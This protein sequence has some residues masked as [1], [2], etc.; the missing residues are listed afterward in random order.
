MELKVFELRKQK[1]HFREVKIG[2]QRVCGVGGGVKEVAE[3]ILR[4][5]SVTQLNTYHRMHVK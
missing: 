5:P 3:E 2:L 1:C 4:E